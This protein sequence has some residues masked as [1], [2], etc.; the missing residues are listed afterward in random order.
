[1]ERILILGFLGGVDTVPNWTELLILGQICNTQTAVR[2]IIMAEHKLAEQFLNS[3]SLFMS[4]I[5]LIM[6]KRSRKI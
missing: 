1:M 2:V 4:H 3:D 5:T 6:W